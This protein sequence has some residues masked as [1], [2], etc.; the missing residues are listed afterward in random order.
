MKDE[1]T[2]V[3]KEGDDLASICLTNNGKCH[4]FL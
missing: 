2:F 4:G 3:A 1:Y